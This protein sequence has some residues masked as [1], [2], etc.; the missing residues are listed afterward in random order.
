MN[1][2][3]SNLMYILIVPSSKDDYASVNIDNND[4][5]KSDV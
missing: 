2:N 3:W 4:N 5:N 1:G